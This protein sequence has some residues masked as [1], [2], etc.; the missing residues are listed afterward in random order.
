MH[1]IVILLSLVG[2]YWYIFEKTTNNLYL[3]DVLSSLE[4]K[5]ISNQGGRN[6]WLLL[7]PNKSLEKVNDGGML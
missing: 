5:S 2:I 6:Q 7:L 4:A 3:K 1:Y